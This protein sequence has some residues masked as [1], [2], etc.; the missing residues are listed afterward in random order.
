MKKSII[1][2]IL[3]CAFVSSCGTGF[4][5]YMSCEGRWSERLASLDDDSVHIG[6][7]I[8]DFL[9]IWGWSHPKTEELYGCA[10]DWNTY[11]HE[12][13]HIDILTYVLGNPYSYEPGSRPTYYR[14]YFRNGRLSSFS[15]S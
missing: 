10:W 15:K 3:L 13:T 7:T 5:E 14:F 12:R 1:I 9:H 6:M 8:H 4:Y 2:S 11:Q